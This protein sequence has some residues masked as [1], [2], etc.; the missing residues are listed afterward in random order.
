M[1]HGPLGQAGTDRGL[2]LPAPRGLDGAVHGP[3]RP[4][5]VTL[6]VQ[7]WGSLIG[8]RV[9]GDRP[10]RVARLVVANG[11]LPVVTAGLGPIPLS[12]SLRTQHHGDNAIRRL[13][14][15]GRAAV[16]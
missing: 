14:R 11:T 4:D 15:D 13:G 6:F 8:L 2:P 3:P 10:D 9:L 12:D 7:D 1:W 5:R 16:D